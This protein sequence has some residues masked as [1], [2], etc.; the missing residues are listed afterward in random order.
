MAGQ[1]GGDPARTAR[2]ARAASMPGVGYEGTAISGAGERER[3]EYRSLSVLEGEG[4]L[5][6]STRAER[7]NGKHSAP[8]LTVRQL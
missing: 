5:Q 8:T 3:I 4:V 1:V 7:P 6:S 2:T